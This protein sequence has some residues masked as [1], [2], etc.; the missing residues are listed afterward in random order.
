MNFFGGQFFAGGFFGSAQEQNSGGWEPRRRTK[1]DV[2]EG[3]RRL[4]ILPPKQEQKAL[5]ALTQ[6]AQAS[7][8]L[9]KSR[10]E[11]QAA[12]DALLAQ[13]RAEDLFLKAYLAVYPQLVQ[14][15]I[16]ETFRIEA[17]RKQAEME[18]EAFALL[19]LS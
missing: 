12:T 15:Q 17:A 4:G 5:E 3:R 10:T 16:L 11:S 13:Q 8:A 14:S 9:E 19:L 2:E 7:I 18:E 1:E 6:A